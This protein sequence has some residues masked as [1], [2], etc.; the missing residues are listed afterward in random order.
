MSINDPKLFRGN[1]V[2]KIENIIGKKHSI[3]I[4]KGIFNHVVKIAK[5]KKIVRKWENKIFV[6]L[7]VNRLK[8]IMTNLK[9]DEV[10]D[11]ILS[12]E[13]SVKELS[14][15]THLELLP[16]KWKK[17]LD[18]KL[19]RDESLTSTNLSAAT[20]EFKCYKCK[21]RKCTY[22]QLQTRS[23]DEPMTTFVSCLVCGNRWKC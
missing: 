15:A 21:K 3:N 1:I 20:D 23:A 19:K 22:Y 8:M 10:K 4:E 7:Y 16:N 11:K 17:L 14:N 9:Y 13:I 12:G 2:K 6:M 18:A 5:K